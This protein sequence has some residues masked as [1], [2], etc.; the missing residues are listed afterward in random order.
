MNKDSKEQKVDQFSAL[1]EVAS[2]IESQTDTR[3]RFIKKAI[4]TAP[5]ILTVTAGPVW[6][7]KKA[8]TYSGQMSLTPT[9][10]SL[11]PCDGGEGCSPG[12]W[13][14]HIGVWPSPYKTLDLFKDVFFIDTFYKNGGE[15]NLLDVLVGKDLEVILPS[16]VGEKDVKKTTQALINLGE[17]AVAALLNAASTVAYD[18]PVDDI[19]AMGLEGVIGL[20]GRAYNSADKIAIESLKDTFDY[21]NN[22]NEDCPVLV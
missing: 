5:V 11:E 1:E 7:T 9:N 13:K 22:Q 18:L 3:R 21:F 17:A 20:F 4:A 19:P 16:G 8:C 6:A 15:A 2:H 14:K 10:Y 12:F